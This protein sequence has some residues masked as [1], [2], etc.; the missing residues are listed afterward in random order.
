MH[1]AEPQLVVQ[2][3]IVK[4]KVPDAYLAP[5]GGRWRKEGGP[6]VT[7]DFIARGDVAL[8][9]LDCRDAQIDKIIKWNRGLGE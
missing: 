3:Q 8:A 5:C 9:A 4:A 1:R 2:H 6:A 7:Q